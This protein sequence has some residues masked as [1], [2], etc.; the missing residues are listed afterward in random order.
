MTRTAVSE[1]D[2]STEL[3]PFAALLRRYA[4]AYVAAHDFSVCDQIM[5]DDYELRMGTHLIQGRDA[6]KPA[7]VRQYRQFPGL[8]FTVHELVLNGDRAALHFTEHGWSVLHGGYCAWQ[9]VSLYRWDGARLVECRLEQDYFARRRQL[10]TKEP[11]PVLPPGWDPWLAPVQAPRPEIED[12]VRQWIEAGHL[13]SSPFGSL[14]DEASAPP[15]RP[16]LNLEG[17]DV[18]DIFS[19]GDV[20]VFRAVHRGRYRGG[21]PN[22]KGQ[23]GKSAT[24]YATGIVTVERGSVTKVRAITDR[25]G[26]ER[27]LAAG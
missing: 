5:V 14:D 15:C 24:L 13:L 25:L 4:F 18:D 12:V 27:H 22:S 10:E 7:T 17:V 23:E 11:N 1:S 21:L 2:R 26:L 20:A 9:G 16:E 6:Y 19:A 3:H 8:G